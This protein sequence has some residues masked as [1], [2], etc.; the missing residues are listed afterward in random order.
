MYTEKRIIKKIKFQSKFSIILTQNGRITT[1]GFQIDCSDCHTGK[2]VGV[3]THLATWLCQI[4]TRERKNLLKRKQQTK[5][6][7]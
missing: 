6:R 3:K 5:E 1:Y 7:K 2:N 4:V